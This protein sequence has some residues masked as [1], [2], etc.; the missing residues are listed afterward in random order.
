MD[1]PLPW[2]IVGAATAGF[3][4]GLTGFGFGLVA[5][6]FWAWVLDPRLAA[7]LAVFG[8]LTGQLLAAFTVRRGFDWKTVGPFIAGGLIGLPVGLLL[9][10]HLD[11]VRF[12][13]GVGALLALWCPVMLFS[14]RLPRLRFGGRWA[15]GVAG[16]CGGFMGPLG[17]F[18]GAI[19]TLWCTLRGLERDAQRAVIQNFNLALLA[20]TM[21]SY[22]ASGIVTRPMLP[23]M[24]VVAPALVLPA[25]AGMKVY[26]GISPQAFRKVVLTLLTAS[27]VV[28]LASALPQL[29]GAA[30]SA[31]P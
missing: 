29:L 18:T 17:G 9:L 30:A 1:A 21:A 13:A 28:M 20:T 8:A 12:R 27:G 23:L 3:V 31:R 19:P 15:D 10:P 26:V 14:E 6:S 2:I 24:G 5:M 22:L 7:V 11:A 4:Q 16:A 25:L